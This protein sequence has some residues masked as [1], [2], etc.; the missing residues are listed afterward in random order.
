MFQFC[1]QASLS[2]G[3]HLTEPGAPMWNDDAATTVRL[4]AGSNGNMEV[5]MLQ[6]FG[7]LYAP[8]QSFALL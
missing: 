5:V 6:D 4:A 7:G 2:T 3:R 1:S 8:Y